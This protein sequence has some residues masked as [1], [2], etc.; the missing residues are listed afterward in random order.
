MKFQTDSEAWAYRGGSDEV[1]S[2]DVG[3]FRCPACDRDCAENNIFCATHRDMWRVWCE[4]PANRELN[5]RIATFANEH[6]E[7]MN[8]CAQCD[9]PKAEQGDYLCSEC[10]AGWN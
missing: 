1:P 10:R 2:K 9:L 8:Y 7:V 5:D 3:R 4:K 6:R